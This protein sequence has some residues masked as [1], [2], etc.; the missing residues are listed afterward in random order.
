MVSLLVVIGAVVRG[1]ALLGYSPGLLFPDSWGYIATGLTGS[2][3]GLPTVHPIGYPILIRLLTLPG[4]SLAELIALQHLAA[5]GV[6]LAVYAA[7]HRN[8]WM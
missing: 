1:L 8:R 4:R 2:F 5:L 6:G 3:V 7:L